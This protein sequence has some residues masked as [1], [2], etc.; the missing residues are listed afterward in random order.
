MIDIYYDTDYDID[1]TYGIRKVL[2]MLKDKDYDLKEFYALDAFSGDGT[3]CTFVIADEV[4]QIDC[5]EKDEIIF[6]KLVDNFSSKNSV[7]EFLNMD[8]IQYLKDA[9]TKNYDLIHMDAP[10][11][12]YG[13]YAEY[14]DALP[15]ITRMFDDET[16]LIHDIVSKPYTYDSDSEWGKK[17]NE[18][19]GLDDCS[20]LDLDFIKEFHIS[21][22]KNMNIDVE[23][24][25]IIPREM[26]KDEVYFHYIVYKLRK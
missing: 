26:Y 16:I 25:E 12:M 7:N 21:Y 4:N 20:T 22:F 11:G 23:W 13:S 14:F 9:R 17:R 24:L 15:H 2:E 5:I 8:A 10:L 3:F 18:F 1:R 19:Y 6:K